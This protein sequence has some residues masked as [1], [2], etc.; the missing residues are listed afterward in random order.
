M[1]IVH[2]TVFNLFICSSDAACVWGVYRGQTQ[3]DE[4]PVEWGRHGSYWPTQPPAHPRSH[5]ARGGGCMGRLCRPNSGG[6]GPGARQHGGVTAPYSPPATRLTQHACNTTLRIHCTPMTTTPNYCTLTLYHGRQAYISFGSL[7]ASFG[8]LLIS[9]EKLCSVHT[10]FC[11][12]LHL[13][14][15]SFV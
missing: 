5:D 9:A 1:Y 14:C 12:L 10:N 2:Y 7:F 13:Q 15:Y 3:V 8:S 4:A 11:F 6:W